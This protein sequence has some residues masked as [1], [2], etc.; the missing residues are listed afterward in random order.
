MTPVT[1]GRFTTPAYLLNLLTMTTLK[2]DIAYIRSVVKVQ[3]LIMHVPLRN[4]TGEPVSLYNP[5]IRVLAAAKKIFGIT[6][7]FMKGLLLL[8]AL[9]SKRMQILWVKLL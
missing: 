7:G 3:L 2:R 9:V 8:P 1:A 5:A 4:G 6:E